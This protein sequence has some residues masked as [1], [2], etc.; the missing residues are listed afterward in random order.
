MRWVLI[1][2]TI[3]ILLSFVSFAQVQ[4]PL[5]Y[6]KPGFHISYV[7]N[8][9]TIP[10]ID[11]C[12]DVLAGLD[13]NKN[14]KLEILAINDPTVSSPSSNDTTK[15]IFWFEN[16][17]NDNYKLLWSVGLPLTSITTGYSFPG[18][19]ITD[20]DGDGNYEITVVNPSNADPAS[21][22]T[23]PDKIFFYEYDPQTKTFPTEPTFSWNLDYPADGEAGFR[24]TYLYA[25]DFDNDG[26][27]EIALIDRTS[28]IHMWI[29]SLDGNDL[30]PFS[31]FKIEFQDSSLTATWAFDIAV[32]DFDRDGKKE[33]WFGT[34]T[35]FTWVIVEAEG[36]DTYVKKKVVTNSH[37][38]S[39]TLVGTLRSLK[40]MDMDGDGYPEGFAMATNGKL[41]FIENK[42]PTDVSEIDSTY[43]YKVGGWDYTR[44]ADWGDLDGDGNLD[45]IVAGNYRN[46]YHIEYK[47][48]GPFADS[49]SWEWDEFLSDTLGTPRYYYVSIPKG[50]MDGDGK[51]EVVIGSLQRPDSTRGFFI[52][53]ESDVAVKVQAQ[54]D[55]ILMGYHLS[56]N[57]PN[58]FNPTTWIKFS[59]PR[60]EFISLKIYT[61]DG[62][63]V[64]TLVEGRYYSAGKHKITWDGTDE[65]GNKVASGVYI[66]KISAGKFE[67]SKKMLLLR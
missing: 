22:V 4:Y 7:A 8:Y 52:V 49:T 44:G 48:S 5:Y 12:D 16:D 21:G 28:N 11:G 58:P 56:Q 30:N 65:N 67:A 10:R 35:N 25:D 6:L 46:V 47:G 63:L 29:I 43:F 41:V 50:D 24:L 18:V 33:V 53:F 17:G 15:W 64:K 66:Y 2:L 26:K 3:S 37:I 40:F 27:Q 39:G 20:V 32:T 34:W 45:V 61:V 1:S 23:N 42:K 59:I 19:N 36:P 51:R 31:T 13:L 62:R 14:G 38:G 54:N 57:Y 9:P 55:E 60:D